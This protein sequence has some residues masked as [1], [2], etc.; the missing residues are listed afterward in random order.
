MLRSIYPIRKT[1]EESLGRDD[2]FVLE[3]EGNIVATAI[4]NRI[5]VPEY[6]YADW[7]YETD[8][9]IREI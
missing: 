3:D 2:L 7:K 4:I 1:A 5:Q 6:R 8:D 9:S